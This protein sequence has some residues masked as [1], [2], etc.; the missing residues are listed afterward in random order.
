MIN[1]FVNI[2]QRDRQNSIPIPFLLGEIERSESSRHHYSS[3]SWKIFDKRMR[4]EVTFHDFSFTYRN[5][6][7]FVIRFYEF[8][9]LLG[10]RSR[11]FS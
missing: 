6:K 4:I 11:I 10:Q 2:Y 7:R 8:Q 9:Q 1:V 3:C 5:F